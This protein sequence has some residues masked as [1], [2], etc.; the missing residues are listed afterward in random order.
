MRDHKTRRESRDTIYV[1]EHIHAHYII[2]IL[3]RR[4]E[5]ETQLVHE[6]IIHEPYIYKSLQLKKKSFSFQLS[7]SCCPTGRDASILSWKIWC[8]K[9]RSQITSLFG[10]T[11]RLYVICTNAKIPLTHTYIRYFNNFLKMNKT[12]TFMHS[13]KEQIECIKN[14]LLPRKTDYYFKSYNVSNIAS[15]VTN[16]VRNV[17]GPRYKK[18]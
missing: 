8:P 1:H 12:R 7:Y 3:I 15:R 11:L 16:N 10:H 4:H 17:D 18:L 6:V 14:M 5:K 2:H 9:G 13:L